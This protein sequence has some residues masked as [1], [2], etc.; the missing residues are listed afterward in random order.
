MATPDKT[1]AAGDGAASESPSPQGR[2]MWV[3]R[4]KVAG[5]VLAVALVQCLAISFY[6]PAPT[7]AA[8]QDAETLLPPE[9]AP[10]GASEDSKD[11]PPEEIEFDLKDF[12]VTAYQPLSNTTLRIDFHLWGLIDPADQ[13]ELRKLME[14]KEKR[15]RDQVI[16]TI[17]G[18]DLNDFTDAGLAL[19][20][21][22]ILETSNKTLGKPLL[23]RI[24][25]SDFSFIEQ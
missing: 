8:S 12:R 22:R 3:R 1:P 5:I 13:E 17:R 24:V 2:R 18:A 23:K 15:F 19:I 16:V 14:S 20:K 25:F 4:L 9:L 11:Q 6:L 7:E 21:R 10:Q